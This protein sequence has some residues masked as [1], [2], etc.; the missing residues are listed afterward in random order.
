MLKPRNLPD[1]ERL[2][3]VT[4]MVLLAYTLARF[5]HLPGRTFAVQFPGIYLEAVINARTLI[6]LLAGV[7][8]AS[9]AAWLVSDHP[10]LKTRG[11]FGHW[12]LP[13]LTAWVVGFPLFDLPNGPLLWIGMFLGGGLLVLVLLAEYI[14]IDP[15]DLRQPVAAAG[16]IALSFA[17]YLALAMVLRFAGL[18][19]F[20]LLPALALGGFGVCLR[21][22]H[23]RLQG[24]WVPI[25]ALAIT[26]VFTQIGAA[27]HYW[28]L[29]PISYGLA[30]LGPAYA[31][32]S[33][34]A[35]LM[36]GENLRQVLVEPVIV[37]LI[38]WAFAIWMR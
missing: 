20:L 26:L 13:A 9:G 32:T 15:D 2:S 8:T 31:A 23:L 21:A 5:V 22:L 34:V 14:V 35:S 3:V 17:L 7:L 28:P 11:V 30:L 18:R 10:A 38:V 6:T 36:E 37:L 16:L 33:L 29:S 4:V 25:Q 19:L 1:L 24:Q 12:L 27:L